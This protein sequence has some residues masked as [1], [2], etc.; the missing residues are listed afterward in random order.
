LAGAEHTSLDTRFSALKAVR[1][2][3]VLLT[4][5]AAA[6]V[7][8]QLGMPLGEVV[9]ISLA[10]MAVCLGGQLVDALWDKR[11]TAR[12]RPWGSRVPLQR[13]LVPVDS[14]FLAIV[15][16]PS[17]G[18]Q[19]DFIWLFTVEL[20]SVTLLASPRT[21]LRLAMWD[22]AL[23]VAIT[24]LRL[25]TPLA[26][27]LGATQ[28]FTLSA[29]AVAVRASG[30]GAVALCTACFSALSERELRRSK[31]Q[32]DA[33]TQMAADM[34][35]AMEGGCGA[36]GTGAIL[37]RSLLGPFGFKQV[38]FVWERGD[39][40]TAA[41]CAAATDGVLPVQALTLGSEALTGA[42]VRRV[43]SGG[44]PVLVHSLSASG[45]PGLESLVPNAVN[46][47]VIAL[48][49]GPEREGLLVAEYGPP[50]TRRLSRRSLEM[51]SRFGAHAA[52]A[53]S[54]ADLREEVERLA[55][56]DSL[57]GLANR[58]ALGTVLSREVARAARAK[59]PLSV[60]IVDID[61][62]KR[63]NDTFGHLVGDEVLR[64][65]AKAMAAKVR[66]VDLLARYGGEEFAIVLP[67]CASDGALVVIERVRAAVAS[68]DMVT[69]V[70][71][72]AGIATL[73]GPGYDGEGLLAAADEALYA[74]KRAGRD[75]VTV[76]Q[77]ALTTA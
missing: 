69:S 2:A 46:V 33:L 6:F 22:S 72:S 59:E 10:Y 37:L 71:V 49:A 77:K 31:A 64:T 73:D 13:M 23:L 44:G 40:V 29:G 5:T 51:V 65:V 3:V 32:L 14:V 39:R 45:T 63:V 70:T 58:R 20:I 38:G 43:L 74:S 56:S 55:A 7:P 28:A 17:G 11:C 62:F 15:T 34:E 50:T 25:G 60:A 67:N 27:L 61:H 68:A 18:A 42:V 57:T 48:R 66:D 36:D 75:R 4:V 8:R 1:L 76:A 53:L 41:R 24:L 16:L 30:F 12:P 47:V 19:S 9:P 35:E 54:N 52:L 21:G 26:Q